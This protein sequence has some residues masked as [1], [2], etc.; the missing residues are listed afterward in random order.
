MKILRTYRWIYIP[1]DIH[2]DGYMKIYNPSQD[3]IIIY[4]SFPGEQYRGEKW[5]LIAGACDPRQQPKSEKECSEVVTK[6]ISKFG[7]TGTITAKKLTGSNHEMKGIIDA[8]GCYW[9]Q[10]A[11]NLYYSD[12]GEEVEEGYVWISNIYCTKFTRKSKKGVIHLSPEVGLLKK[13]RKGNLVKGI[14]T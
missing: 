3:I 9:S 6:M 12:E 7:F 10:I 4:N 1:V 5:H 2:T 11:S 8:P 13:F 14:C